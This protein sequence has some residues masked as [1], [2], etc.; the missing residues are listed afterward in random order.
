MDYDPGGVSAISPV[1]M[2]LLLPSVVLNTWAR[3]TTIAFSRLNTF[4]LSH[5]GLRSSCLRFTHAVTCIN[6]KLGSDGRLTL[7]DWLFNQLDSPSF[8]WRTKTLLRAVSSAGE[9]RLPQKTLKPECRHVE[10]IRV[11]SSPK[12]SIA[13]GLGDQVSARSPNFHPTAVAFLQ[14]ADANR[15]QA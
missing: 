2:T 1:T 11:L 15:T 9:I 4:T 8:T 3:S 7:S 14:R 12:Q 13:A 5:Y 10:S 6:A